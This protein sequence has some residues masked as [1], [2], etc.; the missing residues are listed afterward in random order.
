MK[1]S[2]V[3]LNWKRLRF[4]WERFVE[5]K[6]NE[7]KQIAFM[8]KKSHTIFTDHF[9]GR[10]ERAVKSQKRTLK[11]VTIELERTSIKKEKTMSC[12]NCCRS[13]RNFQKISNFNSDNFFLANSTV[14]FVSLVLSNLN[15][16]KLLLLVYLLL[17]Y[18]YQKFR[19]LKKKK[20]VLCTSMTGKETPT[21]AITV[22]EIQ[23]I[24]YGTF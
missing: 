21:T 2:V 8:P 10:S 15:K 9:D 22:F 5:R 16:Y 3:G 14:V 11:G 19:S 23:N 13:V 6:T 1:N 20:S 12:A 4:L 7:I 24:L 18:V 17:L